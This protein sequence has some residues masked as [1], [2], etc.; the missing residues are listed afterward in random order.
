MVWRDDEAVWSGR[1]KGKTRAMVSD[2]CRILATVNMQL[3][4]KSGHEEGP[5]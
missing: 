1:Q 5:W 2:M 3:V 4:G